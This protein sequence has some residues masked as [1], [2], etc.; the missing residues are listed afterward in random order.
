MSHS[1]LLVEIGTEEL[2]P[3]SLEQLRK[4]FASEL[5]AQLRQAR[6]SFGEVQS[7]A[8]PRRLAVLI[9]TLNPEQPDESVELLGP[10][11]EIAIGSDGAP[12]QAALGFM[13]KCGVEDISQ[14]EFVAADKG[15][16][17]VFRES[18]TG[19]SLES[20]LPAAIE[21]ALA[22]L[23]IAKRMR[24]GA[25]K[26]EFV[27]PVHWVVA[28]Y[29]DRPLAIDVMGIRAGRETHG[30]RFHCPQ[31]IQLSSAQGYVQQLFDTAHVIADP[32][33]RKQMIIHQVNQAAAAIG[34]TAV[35]EPA[36]LNEV[37]ALVEWPVALCGR[38]DE[39]FLQ[40]PE[41][42]LISSMGEHQ[43]Y[44]HVR[45]AAGKLMPLFITLSNLDSPEPQRIID[46]NERVIRP[47]LA[48]ARF[49]Y[50]TDLKTPLQSRFE[51]LEKI[52]FQADL[53]S[54]ADKSRRVA[55]L[56]TFLA[57]ACKANPAYVEQAAML[58]KCD[59]VSEM[60]LE[61][62]HLQGIMGRYYALA[63]GA[64][65]E[66]AA[67]IFEQ[68]LPQHA[69][70]KLPE[71]ATGIALALAERL[72]TL[73]GIF[74][75]GQPP[76]G[77]RDPYALRRA[78]IGVLNI[79]LQRRIELSLDEA[80]G[81]AVDGYSQL[82]IERSTLIEQIQSYLIDRFRAM[83]EEQG[84]P[85]EV[86]RAVRSVESNS[87]LEIQ[88][89]VAAVHEFSQTPAAAQLAETNK[90][91]ANILA[92]QGTQAATGLNASLLQEEAEIALASAV[93]L[94]S[95]QLDKLMPAGQLKQS[96]EQLA[97]LQPAL[98]SFFEQ[99]MVM[100]DDEALR[101]NRLALLQ[102][103]RNQVLRVADLSELG[104]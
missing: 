98:E 100:V 96:L 53:G 20:L 52:V 66:V 48:D 86:F 4:A 73:A 6:L 83:F 60:V 92:K 21:T 71:T 99:V 79:L 34:G 63:D 44:F 89:R 61:F 40:V 33:E 54:I 69:G 5:G 22:A 91:V 24:W 56:A 36:L 58:A 25:G 16:R 104:G 41:E 30:H 68:Y 80:L 28:L 64:P 42:A 74:G 11:R 55:K 9:E 46:G 23:P 70:D 35:M 18:R 67:A 90:R 75:I 84:T 10:S 87:P 51:K 32:L 57:P 101:A 27:R 85:V 43:K 13:R 14:L 76:T 95:G 102:A 26:Q 31:P 94:A 47:R 39:S 93:A 49:F 62:D 37:T 82:K 72:D 50:E 29:G 17:L 15:E 38:F 2:P 77:S 88:R 12:T 97:Q 3:K 59:L 65:E 19:A 45:D 81:A 7:Y 78:S 103:V 1:H 8:T